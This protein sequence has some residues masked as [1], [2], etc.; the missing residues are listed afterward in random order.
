MPGLRSFFKT[1]ML[2]FGLVM[3]ITGCAERQ[4]ITVASH[5]WVG[6]E[7]MFLAR[8]MG[9]LDPNLAR[10][11]ET[12]SATESVQALREGKVDGAALTLDELL[13]AR[14]QGIPLTAVLVFDVSAGADLVLA[15][16]SL[17]TLSQL[18]QQ[19]IGVEE[20][21]VGMMMLQA[22]LERAGL[23][24]QDVQVINLLADDHVTAWKKGEVDAI[25]TYEPAASQIR[26]LGAVTL[27][28]SS[29]IPGAIVD[30]LA[31]RTDRLDE[32]HRV[33][34]EHLVSAHF[35]GLL[36][37]QRNPQDAAFRMASHLG[38][39][40]SQVGAAYRGLFLPD[41]E[42]NYRMLKGA[43]ATLPNSANILVS[44]MVA[45]RLL[46]AH[47]GLEKLVSAD[48]LPVMP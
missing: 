33:A 14:S 40:P 21:A 37:F 35:Q 15:R 42:N 18:K 2:F 45:Q 32:A 47:D 6:Y 48:Y 5:V 13:R 1:G 16:P 28:D 46:P 3:F 10:L 26:D 44:K 38:L 23:T 20:G 39:K 24:A 29:Q 12:A 43:Q 30:V 36:H 19:R 4:P 11:H 7:P 8:E 17:G 9:R 27:F 34:L 25:V 31:I 41:V 22:A